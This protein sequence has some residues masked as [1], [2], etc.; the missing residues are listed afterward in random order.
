MPHPKD[1]Y[2]PG[3]NP[4]DLV[5]QVDKR[6]RSCLDGSRLPD[7]ADLFNPLVAALNA[8]VPAALPANPHALANDT[9]VFQET[10]RFFL[11]HELASTH[12]LMILHSK[13]AGCAVSVVDQ[14][15]PLYGNHTPVQLQLLLEGQLDGIAQQVV[16]GWY[17]A[18][19]GLL[20]RRPSADIVALFHRFGTLARFADPM[21]QDALGTAYLAAHPV[22][23]GF[24]PVLTE[25]V[26]GSLEQTLRKLPAVVAA[27]KGAS[28]VP[29]RGGVDP[30]WA[31]APLVEADH[32]EHDTVRTGLLVDKALPKSVETIKKAL[33]AL[34]NV[35]SPGVQGQL[36]LPR[37][38][39]VKTSGTDLNVRAFTGAGGINITIGETDTLD[40]VAHE[41]GHV[42]ENVLP[43][44][45]WLDLVRLLHARHTAAGGGTLLPIYPG[46][47]DPEV[48]KECAYRAVMPVSP[49]RSTTSGS[50][51]AKVYG[52]ESAT[53]LLSTTLELLVTAK[54][55]E[56][57]LTK[58]PQLLAVVLRWLLGTVGVQAAG[59]T[60][61][62]SW[63]L[64]SPL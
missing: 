26:R 28:T 48:A 21:N 24:K 30:R 6:I 42:I 25:Q 53:E 29:L 54:G 22:A 40:V 7:P 39:V 8:A 46:H 55:T 13:L 27:L 38:T 37:F 34:S 36:P 52:A 33:T 64:P 31:T 49:P 4:P 16:D 20:R 43:I 15:D 57:L 9:Q 62:L 1:Q 18:G 23:P 35:I 19:H 12:D 41:V 11:A 45:C 47:A 61:M 3:D 60:L 58:D 32:S 2:L 56:T 5:G 51:A 14:H 50:Y 63:V 10:V 44:G 17:N 59:N